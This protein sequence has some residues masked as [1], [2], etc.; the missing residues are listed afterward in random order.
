M[1]SIS[2]QLQGDYLVL[3]Y[4]SNRLDAASATSFK[5]QVSAAIDRHETNTIVDLT[6]VEFMDSSGLGAIV[7]AMKYLGNRGALSVVGCSEAVDRVFR[8]TRMD[9]VIK[10]GS[11]VDDL[12]SAVA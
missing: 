8:M 10:I 3:S 2:E 9:R 5:E 12:M 6:G 7:G 4:K 1:V 11:S